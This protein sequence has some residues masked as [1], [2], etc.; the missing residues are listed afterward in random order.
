MSPAVTVEVINVMLCAGSCALDQFQCVDY[1]C[2]S[3]ISRCDGS[4]DCE[5]GSDEANCGQ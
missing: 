4:Y 1:S 2:V 3:V 5:D